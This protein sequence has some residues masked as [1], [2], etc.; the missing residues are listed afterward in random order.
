VRN[1]MIYR[2]S[3]RLESLRRLSFS[4]LALSSSHFRFNSDKSL[5]QIYHEHKSKRAE[6]LNKPARCL[7]VFWKDLSLLL[8]FTPRL[9]GGP[10]EFLTCNTD[11]TTESLPISPSTS[12]RCEPIL[13]HNRFSFLVNLHRQIRER[14]DAV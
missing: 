11:T 7:S 10:L 13:A 4:T 3:I 1:S 9:P 6:I 8:S 14:L 5:R 2:I 12:D